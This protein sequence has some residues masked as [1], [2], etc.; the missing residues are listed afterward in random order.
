MKP[1]TLITLAAIVGFGGLLLFTTLEAQQVECTACV[2]FK[3]AENCATASG[4]DS[5]EALRTVVNTA[6]GPLATG[7]AES[8]QCS[9]LPPQR[10][11]C[12]TR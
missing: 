2:T 1:S 3:G 5:L 10:P 7:M 11:Q 12:R 8:I 9:G 6:C 4:T